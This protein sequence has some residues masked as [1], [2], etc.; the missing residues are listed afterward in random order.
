MSTISSTSGVR[1]LDT[2]RPNSLERTKRPEPTEA[3]AETADSAAPPIRD[4]STARAL[5]QDLSSR[6]PSDQEPS[7]AAH[8]PRPGITESLL[9]ES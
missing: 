4:Y 6:I 7:L 8:T 2:L 1:P 9:A 5:V 3:P